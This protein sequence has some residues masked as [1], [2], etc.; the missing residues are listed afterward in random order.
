MTTDEDAPMKPKKVKPER[1]TK[2]VDKATAFPRSRKP[3]AIA[4]QQSELMAMAVEADQTLEDADLLLHV[5]KDKIASIINKLKSATMPTTVT[6]KTPELATKPTKP[7][8]TTQTQTT[9]P[10]PTKPTTPKPMTSKSTP[11]A[12]KTPKK[13]I[14]TKPNTKT[15]ITT[16]TTTPEP[17][18]DPQPDSPA[19]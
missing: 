3:R 2:T 12:A 8:K 10:T 6:K 7:A 5:L 14:T 9:K 18:V 17:A 19:E 13:V 11:N 15:T 16:T 1:R 4:A